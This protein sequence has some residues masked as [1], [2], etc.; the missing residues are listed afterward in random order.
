MTRR[1][2][3]LMLLAIP[4]GRVLSTSLFESASKTASL[5]PDQVVLPCLIIAYLYPQLRHARLPFR[6]VHR[7]RP[8]FLFLVWC[9]ISLMLNKFWYGLTIGQTAFSA[10]YLVRWISYSL[11][12][13]V[14]YDICRSGN[15]VKRIV[16]WLVIG[17]GLFC[18]FGLLQAAFLP[19]F[20]FML[21][22]DA[23]PSVDFDLQGHRLVSTFLDPNIAAGYILIFVLLALSFWIHGYSHWLGIVLLL[24]GA[25]FATLSRGGVLGFFVGIAVLVSMKRFPRKR[26]LM[27]VLALLLLVCVMYPSFKTLIEDTRRI[28]IDDP[29]ALMRIEDWK[30]ALDIISSNPLVG[31]G[32]DTLGFVAPQYGMNREGAIA[33]GFSGDLVTIFAL[34]GAIGLILYLLIYWEVIKGLSRLRDGTKSNWVRAYSRGVHASTIAVVVSSCFTTILLY[35]QIMGVLWIL[36]A[37]GRRLQEGMD[38]EAIQSGLELARAAA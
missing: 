6:E 24:G 12:Y 15:E 28:S 1:L 22:P 37:L 26:A 11:L 35:P 21:H 30:L 2:F 3:Y 4:A 19:D 16:K 25:L 13:F 38:A 32:F 7:A 31:I 33:F 8:L 10:L 14:A 36:W 34:T 18:A 5:T 23:I 20:A 29:S 27:G 17:G 9:L